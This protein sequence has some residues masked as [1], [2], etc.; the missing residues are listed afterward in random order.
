MK[1]AFIAGFVKIGIDNGLD[2]EAIGKLFKAAMEEPEVKSIFE[3]LA[4]ENK[5]SLSYNDLNSLNIVKKAL[6]TPEGVLQ[7][8]ELLNQ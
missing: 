4:I 7:L 1:E 6:Q 8:K 2:D 5:S 3:K